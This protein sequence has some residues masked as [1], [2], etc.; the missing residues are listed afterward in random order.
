MTATDTPV[1]I[2][3]AIS[4]VDGLVKVTGTARYAAEHQVPGLLY[5]WVVSSAIAKGRITAFR[6]TDARA[7]PGVVEV[8]THANRPHVAW[9]DMSYD[10]EVAVPGSPF[11]PL[12]DDEVVFAMQPVALVIGETLE[13]GAC[14]RGAARRRLRAGSAQ[15]GH[16]GRAGRQVRAEEIAQQLPDA[17][18]AR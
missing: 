10:D 7:V 5:G 12:Y 17:E 11:R 1:Y 16:R 8:I 14:R 4:R 15:H 13:A 9:L 3:S 2:G 6:D 18:E